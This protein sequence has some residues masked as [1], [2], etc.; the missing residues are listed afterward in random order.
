MNIDLILNENIKLNEEVQRYKEM[1][2]ITN[3]SLAKYRKLEEQ[4]GCSLDVVVK[5]LK[6]H[7]Y[8]AEKPNHKGKL[9]TMNF[10]HI[11]FVIKGGKASSMEYQDNSFIVGGDCYDFFNRKMNTID[12]WDVHLKDYKKT[13]WLKEDKS[14]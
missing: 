10:P 5:L 4:L 7:M 14:E 6:N 11:S 2:T 8:Y 13:W 12:G 1:W 9:Y 3:N